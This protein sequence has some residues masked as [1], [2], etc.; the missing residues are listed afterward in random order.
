M[1]HAVSQISY[2]GKKQIIV[3]HAIEE[4]SEHIYDE[5]SLNQIL[6]RAN[7]SKGSFYYY[8]KN[9]QDL[10]ETSQNYALWIFKNYFASYTYDYEG[11]IERL[12]RVN[13]FKKGFRDKYPEILK[14]FMQQYYKRLFPKDVMEELDQLDKSFKNTLT[15]DINYELFR[16]DLNLEH[17]LQLIKW[18][19]M[20]YEKNIEEQTK[21]DLYDFTNMDDCFNQ[22]EAYFNTLKAAY[23]K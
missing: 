22:S 11:Y 13:K 21:N 5:A 3:N 10:Y 9:K 1:N 16:D 15:K 18:T 8:F 4:L 2:E 14:F 12:L 20:G 6:L 19:I 17:A 23:Y 7:I